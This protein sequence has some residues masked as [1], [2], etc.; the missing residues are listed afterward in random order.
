MV[1]LPDG[2]LLV[3]GGS[4]EGVEFNLP[5]NNTAT[6]E[7]LP[8][9][10]ASAN[11]VGPSTTTSTPLQFLWDTLPANLYP[12]TFVLPSG[13][14]F[15]YASDRSTIMDPSRGYQALDTFQIVLTSS[16]PSNSTIPTSS[17]YC[18]NFN[19]AGGSSQPSS[20]G[21]SN[22]S[23]SPPNQPN[24]PVVDNGSGTETNLTARDFSFSVL[25]VQGSLPL[26]QPA[27]NG[28]FSSAPCLTSSNFNQNQSAST[29]QSFIFWKPSIIKPNWDKA[30]VG[31]GS[32]SMDGQGLLMITSAR[33]CLVPSSNAL[34]VSPHKNI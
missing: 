11:I 14:V 18:I 13:R 25:D 7:F 27:S 29:V 10:P 24:N 19:P 21:N 6:F 16:I 8:R 12:E 28:S 20:N 33:G 22:P 31:S 2:R 26:T 15:V 23:S 9:P 17:S 4:N 32:Y 34:S 1:N 5:G 30:P 3:V